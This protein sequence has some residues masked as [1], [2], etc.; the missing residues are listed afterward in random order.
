MYKHKIYWFHLYW[1]EKWLWSTSSSLC[2]KERNLPF[3]KTSLL[4]ANSTQCCMW[5]QRTGHHT[6]EKLSSTENVTFK[7]CN[8]K[9][10]YSSF[11]NMTVRK[12][13]FPRLL[14]FN[15][16][17]TNLMLYKVKKNPTNQPNTE[18]FTTSQP[19]KFNFTCRVHAVF[20]W[21]CIIISKLDPVL[22]FL[23]YWFF[24]LRSKDTLSLT[25][26]LSCIC[27]LS[28]IQ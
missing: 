23:Q 26:K 5:H 10:I 3:S 21:L 14:L 27:Q 9:T 7:A 13:I 28:S 6:K 24:S 8:I 12:T 20:S 1:V 2:G 17:L 15:T 25:Y 4:I 16:S 22:P 18:D 11:R 19:G